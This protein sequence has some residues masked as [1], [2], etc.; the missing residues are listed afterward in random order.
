MW[1]P[2]FCFILTNE[3]TKTNSEVGKSEHS[4]HYPQHNVAQKTSCQKGFVSAH[5]FPLYPLSWIPQML[6][7]SW[8]LNEWPLL[9][10]SQCSHCTV[11]HIE[12][13]NYLLSFIT[14]AV[15]QRSCAPAPYIMGNLSWWQTLQM[16]LASVPSREQDS[17]CLPLSF[18]LLENN[19][20]D[21]N[22]KIR[23]C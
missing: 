18:V 2:C 13:E 23:Y 1:K 7:I 6:K 20:N 8:Y 3:K 4:I 11:S 5:F 16:E 21:E 15:L 22:L 12:A 19:N 14:M 17:P 9:L 10:Q